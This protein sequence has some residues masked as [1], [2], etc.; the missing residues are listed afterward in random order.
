[1]ADLIFFRWHLKQKSEAM[2]NWCSR[3]KISNRLRRRGFR[4]LILSSVICSLQSV[5]GSHI[6]AQ[7][8]PENLSEII[9]KRLEVR[10]P[11][12]PVFIPDSKEQSFDPNGSPEVDAANEETKNPQTNPPQPSVNSQVT[13]PQPAAPT[14][15]PQVQSPQLSIP[16]LL[17][18]LP[19]PVKFIPPKLYVGKE[20]LRTAAM[21]TRFY[22]GRGHQPAWTSSTGILPNVDT[23]IQLLQEEA[24][25]EGLQANDYHLAKIKAILTEVRSG[26]EATKPIPPDTFVD[27][28]FL[29]T[30]T[31]LR[32]GADASLGDV[33][34][35]SLTEKWFEKNGETD[36]VL[37]L[38][39]ALLTNAVE[40]TLKSFPPQQ[41]GYRKLR[42]VF[43]QYQTLAFQGGWPTVPTGVTL[44]LG[45]HGEAVAKLQAR[46]RA[47]GDLVAASSTIVAS[48]VHTISTEK[49][50]TL[51]VPKEE[52]VFDEATEHAVKNFQR[53]HNLSATGIVNK[54]TLAAL[55]VSVDIRV[56]QIARNLERWRRLPKDLGRRYIAVNVPD[57]MLE[58]VENDRLVMDM[59][60]VVGKIMQERTTPTF[61]ASM[62]Y[63]VL[64][65]YWNVPKT[66]AQKELLPL[67][68]RNPAYLARNNFTIRRIPVGIKQVPDPNATD[69]SLMSV[70]TYEYLLRQGPGPK[71]ALGR[72]KFMF[73]NDHSVYLHD[74]PSKDLFTRTIRAF[75]HG[76]I[77]IEKPIDLAEYLLQGTPKGSRDAILATLKRN[78]EQTVWLPEPVPVHIQYWTAWVDDE[79]LLQFRND[80]YGYDRLPGTRRL[81]ANVV[82]K[83]RP[84]IRKKPQ[85]QLEGPQYQPQPEIQPQPA[86]PPVQT[87]VHKMM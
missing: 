78:K 3:P 34:L 62:K 63:V 38:Q 86:P 74:T 32:Y 65:P 52:I 5:G 67:S 64:N 7:P 26:T 87:E 72:V 11:P 16:Q 23:F 46:L 81:P 60:V 2:P 47:S 6:E 21:L 79:G 57:F 70:T 69:G 84:K 45:D 55:N 43:A 51:A 25:R 22:E 18:P 19:K 35:D 54:E 15:A 30:D 27:L 61:S 42:E 1:M 31:F 17:A 77:R 76:C 68:R 37:A 36:L 24:E 41:E 71:N 28:D 29:L 56:R 73:P 75:S 80:I 82:P 44:Q 59:K 33:N 48:P 14:L 8:L 10:Q 83:P 85:L 40:V 66:I 39:D 58:V 49:R 50:G 13:Q 12:K 53:R 20:L 4:L 9:L